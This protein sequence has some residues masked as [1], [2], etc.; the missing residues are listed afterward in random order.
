MPAATTPS[1]SV[2]TVCPPTSK[3]SILTCDESCSV[4]SISP[5]G[6]LT[7]DPL[8]NEESGLPVLHPTVGAVGLGHGAGPKTDGTHDNQASLKHRLCQM[9][10]FRRCNAACVS[11]VALEREVVLCGSRG[12]ARAR[13]RCQAALRSERSTA[14]SAACT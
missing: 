8:K 9:D 6:E 1:A 11:A 14:S 10:A 4:N 3:T 5:S 7:R 12:A 2:A 13:R